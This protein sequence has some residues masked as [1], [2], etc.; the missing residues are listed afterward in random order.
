LKRATS[1]QVVSEKA[2]LMRREAVQGAMSRWLSHRWVLADVAPQ[3]A[4]FGHALRCPR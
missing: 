2:V 1:A 4:G 3:E